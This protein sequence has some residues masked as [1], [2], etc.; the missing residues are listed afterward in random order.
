MACGGRRSRES[1]HLSVGY[2]KVVFGAVLWRYGHVGCDDEIYPGVLCVCLCTD[3]E[4]VGAAS[5]RGL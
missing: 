4:M 3:V 5:I 1:G 2:S